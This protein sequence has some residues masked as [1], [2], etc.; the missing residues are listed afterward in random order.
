[1]H[2]PVFS[3]R[4]SWQTSLIFDSAKS[5]DS[6]PHVQLWEVRLFCKAPEQEV[7]CPGSHAAWWPS[8]QA[9]SFPRAYE[10]RTWHFRCCVDT[11]QVVPEASRFHWVG[12][13][14]NGP[15]DPFGSVLYLNQNT[16][17][18]SDC[19]GSFSDWRSLGSGQWFFCLE[20][21]SCY[22]FR[23][24]CPFLF[25]HIGK[26]S[27]LKVERF[28]RPVQPNLLPLCC[29]DPRL[30]AHFRAPP[31]FLCGCKKFVGILFLEV[32]RAWLPVNRGHHCGSQSA[33]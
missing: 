4:W 28:P 7:Q 14:R 17:A 8:H 5:W 16:R 1:M 18:G 15:R 25:C 29:D 3:S 32:Q 23:L 2:K 11:T 10:Q 12:N 21:L 13:Q 33:L 26:N 31:K 27:L 30:S 24:C 19:S 22:P 20:Y 9:F 6:C